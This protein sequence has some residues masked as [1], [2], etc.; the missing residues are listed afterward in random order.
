MLTFI[1]SHERSGIK[2][3]MPRTTVGAWAMS[4]AE[5]GFWLGTAFAMAA[6]AA[7]V[8]AGIGGGGPPG[9]VAAG[10]LNLSQA[11]SSAGF[12]LTF[13]AIALVVGWVV[14]TIAGLLIGTA[15]GLLLS[16]LARTPQYRQADP[17]CRRRAAAALVMAS[18]AALWVAMLSTWFGV[19]L[20]MARFLALYLPA[21]AGSLVAARLSRTLPPVVGWPAPARLG[22]RRS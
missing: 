13:G 17:A 10:I 11:G 19:G 1:R 22:P 7:V 3:R 20:G 5:A 6:V 18:T 14:G 15:N 2:G 12:I 8:L 16:V 9:F 4:G 21:A